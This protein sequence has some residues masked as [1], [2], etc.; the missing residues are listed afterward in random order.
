MEGTGLWARVRTQRHETALWVA[1]SEG[2][3]AVVDALL[4]AGADPAAEDL[5]GVSPLTQAAAYGRV[6]IIEKIARARPRAFQTKSAALGLRRA[7]LNGSKPAVRAM[8][9]GGVPVNARPRGLP[10]ALLAAAVSDVACLAELLASGADHEER[11]RDGLTALHWAVRANNER[12]VRLLLLCGAD[13]NAKDKLGRVPAD[14]AWT[15]S[16]RELLRPV[17]REPLTDDEDEDAAATGPARQ[18]R[19]PGRRCALS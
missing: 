3:R 4:A 1:V 8:L 2:H 16:M 17:V 9:D 10:P 19:S 15:A 11:D 13:R 18:A 7:T 12:S 14:E 5:R 6:D